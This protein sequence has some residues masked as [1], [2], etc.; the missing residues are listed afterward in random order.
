LV[1]IEDSVGGFV[2]YR[3]PWRSAF[4]LGFIDVIR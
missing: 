4:R 3:S 1:K 2:W